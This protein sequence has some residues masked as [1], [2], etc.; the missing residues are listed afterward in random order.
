MFRDRKDAGTQLGYSLEHLRTEHPFVLGIARGGVE[1]GY[2]VAMI[3]DCQFNVLIV[4]KLGYPTRPEAAFGALAED[5]SLYMAPGAKRMISRNQI[6]A[7]IKQEADEIERRVQTYRK[8]HHL[9]SL[10]GRTVILVDDGIATGATL[11]AAIEMCRNHQVR[12]LIVAAPVS[13][14]DTEDQLQTMA[15]EVV[16]LET[17]RNYRAVSTAY[18]NFNNLT[19]DD[20]L[21]FLSSTNIDK[22]HYTK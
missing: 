22:H 5:G 18:I 16:I 14:S 13:S 20:V 7:V 8:G 12:K 19:D 17:P 2:Y 1:V 21:Q 10:A 4:R 9:Q 6:E 11:F 3:L 15:D